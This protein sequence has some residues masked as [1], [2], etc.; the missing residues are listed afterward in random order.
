[1]DQGSNRT[2]LDSLLQ[3]DAGFFALCARREEAQIYACSSTQNYIWYRSHRKHS[4]AKV[5]HVILVDIMALSVFRA[6]EH[7]MP[8]V[9]G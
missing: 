9:A 6:E 8:T 3:V 7:H 1:M 4:L 5:L 2:S